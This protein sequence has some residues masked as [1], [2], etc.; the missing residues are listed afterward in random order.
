MRAFC[1]A[2]LNFPPGAVIG[3]ESVCCAPPTGRSTGAPI[4]AASTRRCTEAGGEAGVTFRRLTDRHSGQENDVGAPTRWGANPVIGSISGRRRSSPASPRCRVNTITRKATIITSFADAAW[5]SYE[6]RRS[7]TLNRCPTA[8]PRLL[9][10]LSRH[11]SWASW[12]TLVSGPRS[13]LASSELR[14]I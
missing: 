13:K 6:A 9:A 8:L 14:K 4:E 3:V 1:S 5:H 11:R 2:S 10:M 12:D 7:K